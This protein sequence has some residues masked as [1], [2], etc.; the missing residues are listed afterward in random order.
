[1]AETLAQREV[2]KVPMGGLRFAQRP[3]VLE[4]LLGSCVGIAVWDPTT[5][6]GGLAHIVLPESYGSCPKPGKFADTAVA[7]LKTG[8]LRRQANAACLK[9]KL[10]GGA[11]MYGERQANDIGARNI[12]AAREQLLR[13]GIPVVAQHVGGT[14]G[15][16]IRFWPH[17]GRIEIATDRELV[18]VI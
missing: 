16:V 11:T 9:A 3:A 4:T 17:D 18:A 10:A 2:V 7:K 5:G 1:M 8:L 14:L 6:L 12:D 13:H 15:R